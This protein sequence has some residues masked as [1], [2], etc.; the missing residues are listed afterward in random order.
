MASISC[1]PT[2][3]RTSQIAIVELLARPD[4]RR[5]LGEAARARAESHYAWRTLG[6][7]LGDAYAT[8]VRSGSAM[9][10]LL[11]RLYDLAPVAVQNR[12]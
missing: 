12:C 8:V 4:E 3:P 5:R 6:E 10:P 7:R 11:K 1:S 2:T 9:S